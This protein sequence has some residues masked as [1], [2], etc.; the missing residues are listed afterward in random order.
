ME[1]REFGLD[2]LYKVLKYKDKQV[3]EE[4]I[5]NAILEEKLNKRNKETLELLRRVSSTSKVL[6]K[7]AKSIEIRK[8]SKNIFSF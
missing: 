8:I 3:E 7:V 6:K 5:R 4:V 2:L 1:I